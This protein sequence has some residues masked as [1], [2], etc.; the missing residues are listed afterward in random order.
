MVNYRLFSE[1]ARAWASMVD[2][3]RGRSSVDRP[4]WIALRTILPLL[5][6]RFRRQREFARRSQ[7][8]QRKRGLTDSSRKSTSRPARRAT[9]SRASGMLLT[10]DL[11]RRCKHLFEALC[12]GLQRSQGR[13]SHRP[14]SSPASSGERLGH[15]NVARRPSPRSPTRRGLSTGSLPAHTPPSLAEYGEAASGAVGAASAELHRR[16]HGHES[17]Q[18]NADPRSLGTNG[19]E[20]PMHNRAILRRLSSPSPR[21]AANERRR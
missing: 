17:D 14:P 10:D 1:R 16:D 8:S 11:A 9:C 2:R 12:D 15:R 19:D 3:V 20:H 6:R 4:T 5:R 21:Q 7:R 18:W 13:A